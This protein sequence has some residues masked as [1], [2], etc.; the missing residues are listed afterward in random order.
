MPSQSLKEI[1]GTSSS[2]LSM[3]VSIIAEKTR[4][5]CTKVSDQYESLDCAAQDLASENASSWLLA[6]ITVRYGN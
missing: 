5:I 3:K 1:Y 6:L 2:R 4:V